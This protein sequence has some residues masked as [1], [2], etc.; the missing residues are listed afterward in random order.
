MQNLFTYTMYHPTPARSAAPS[1][2]YTINRKPVRTFGTRF[3]RIPLIPGIRIVPGIHTTNVLSPS[4]LLPSPPTPPRSVLP[5]PAA[6]YCCYLLLLPAA[7]TRDRYSDLLLSTLPRDRRSYLLAT[8]CCYLLLLRVRLPS[9]LTLWCCVTV[10]RPDF[11]Q[12]LATT[13]ACGRCTT[14]AYNPCY[15]LLTVCS[16]VGWQFNAVEHYKRCITE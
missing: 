8:R 13:A 9:A 1:L 6:A 12:L 4:C 5:L 10:F 2:V 7:V 14:A 15:H 16:Y 11:L 3:L